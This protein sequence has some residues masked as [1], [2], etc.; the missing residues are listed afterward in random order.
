VPVNWLALY[1]RLIAM[2]DM[3]WDDYEVTVPITMHGIAPSGY[4]SSS[5]NP[6]VGILMRWTGQKR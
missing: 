1:D 6:I 2:G 3:T 5:N 4:A